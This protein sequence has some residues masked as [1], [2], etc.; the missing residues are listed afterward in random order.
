VRRVAPLHDAEAHAERLFALSQDLLG[1]ADAEGRLRWVNA[2]WERL[3]GWSADELYS[4]PY[5]DFVHPDDQAKVA[6]FAQRLAH[7]PPGQS[8]QIEC[9]A[10]RRDGG[11]RWLRVSAAV[12]GGEE[13]MVY[14]SGTD[15]TDLHE[16]LA[17]LARSNDELDRFA[18][19]VSH[20]LRQSLTAVLGFLTLLESRHGEMMD[21]RALS[22]LVAAREGGERMRTLVDDLLAYARVGHSGRRPKP[23]DAAELVRRLA[24]TAAPGATVQVDELPVVRAREREFEQLFANLLGNAAKFVAPGTRPWIAVHAAREEDRW[25]FEV[26]DN[27]IG[28]PAPL[29]DRVFGMFQR[30]QRAEDYPGTGIGLAICH[31]IV[32]AAGGRI[33]VRPRDDGGSVFAFTWPA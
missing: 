22:L 23:V 24:A 1:A 33:W 29:A 15:V 6:A 7:L 17:D 2:A 32:E 10:C 28:I 8:L 16:A 25:R 18:S 12:A 11:Y 9:R 4:R 13:P 27:G 21:D 30:L 14:L 19:V 31:K 26:E 20:D 5:L 3:F